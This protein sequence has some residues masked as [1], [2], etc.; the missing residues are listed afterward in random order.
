MGPTINTALLSLHGLATDIDDCVTSFVWARDDFAWERWCN[1]AVRGI[2]DPPGFAPCLRS[3]HGSLQ[4]LH[5]QDWQPSAIWMPL[6]SPKSDPGS[7][8]HCFPPPSAAL[9][10]A[11]C[12]FRDGPLRA[13]GGDVANK[14]IGKRKLTSV[15]SSFQRLKSL[16]KS[17]GEEP[18]FAFHRVTYWKATAPATVQPLSPSFC[19]FSPIAAAMPSGIPSRPLLLQQL[20]YP[21]GRPPPNPLISPPYNCTRR[22]GPCSRR[23]SI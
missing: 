22:P 3:G 6:R 19:S 10:E 17:K 8:L 1:L 15:S 16:C 7:T 21:H 4:C 5:R 12:S 20:L 13:C 11:N 2:S 23:Q 9:A 14:G 18:Q